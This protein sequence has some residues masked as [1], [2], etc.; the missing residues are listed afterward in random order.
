[1]PGQTANSGK[2]GLL[3]QE[4]SEKAVYPG[5]TTSSPLADFSSGIPDNGLQGR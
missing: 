3:L 2:A 1:M 4:V 5:R